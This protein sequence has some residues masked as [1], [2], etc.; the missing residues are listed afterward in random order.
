MAHDQ[1]HGDSLHEKGLKKNK[2]KRKPSQKNT[3]KWFSIF[4]AFVQVALVIFHADI[5]FREKK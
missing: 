4:A 2:K 5:R 1:S 3:V